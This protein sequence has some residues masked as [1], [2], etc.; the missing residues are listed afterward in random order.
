ESE[1]VIGNWLKR[2]GRRDDVVIAT[3]VGMWAKH[4]N[5]KAATIAAAVE[6][7]LKRLKTDYI[8]LYQSHKDDDQTPQDEVLEAYG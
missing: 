3:K 6:D 1:T 5:L 8:D 2:R 7:S 4:P